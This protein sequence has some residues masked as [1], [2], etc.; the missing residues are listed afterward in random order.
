MSLESKE[1]RER[2]QKLKDSAN[3]GYPHNNLKPV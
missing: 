3:Q 1:S 2:K